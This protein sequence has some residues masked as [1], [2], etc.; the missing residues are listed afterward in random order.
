MELVDIHRHAVPKQA[1]QLYQK[2]LGGERE[3]VEAGDLPLRQPLAHEKVELPAQVRPLERPKAILAVAQRAPIIP[4]VIGLPPAGW[5]SGSIAC[6][7][8]LNVTGPSLSPTV[9]E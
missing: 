4:I 7:A 9:A 8:A 1:T 5:R 3:N 6:L 2:R